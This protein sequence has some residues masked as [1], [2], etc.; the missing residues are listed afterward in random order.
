MKLTYNCFLVFRLYVFF[1][2]SATTYD[3][4]FKPFT[5]LVTLQFTNISLLFSFFFFSPLLL[6][7]DCFLLQIKMNL[8]VRT[9]I[10][11]LSSVDLAHFFF[12]QCD[13]LQYY[14]HLGVVATVQILEDSRR[15]K[16]FNLSFSHSRSLQEF[17]CRAEEILPTVLCGTD[18]FLCRNLVG[19]KSVSEFIYVPNLRHN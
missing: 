19:R 14:L 1:F 6:R 15:L 18:K 5:I 3:I 8:K 11:A 10:L 2:P 4:V 13:P 17:D 12:P 9:C 7:D 16:L